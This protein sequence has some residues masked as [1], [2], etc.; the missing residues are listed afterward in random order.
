NRDILPPAYF[1]NIARYVEN[2]GALLLASGPEFADETSIYRT[3]LAAVLPAQPTG[4][5][6]TQAYRPLITRAG[7]A[8]PVTRDLPFVNDAVQAN[9]QPEGANPPPAR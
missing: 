1:D 2:G 5:V 8:H 7:F 3:P 9:T 6:I 4:E